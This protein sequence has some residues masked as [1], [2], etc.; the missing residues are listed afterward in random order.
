MRHIELEEPFSC[1]PEV[2][3]FG[4]EIRLLPFLRSEDLMGEWAVDGMRDVLAR[5]PDSQLPLFLGVCRDLQSEIA[6]SMD[7]HSEEHVDT[8]IIPRLERAEWVGEGLVRMP[9]A[10]RQSLDKFLSKDYVYDFLEEYCRANGLDDEAE[11][12]D[13]APDDMPEPLFDQEGNGEVET[14]PPPVSAPTEKIELLD[15]ASFYAIIGA[16]FWSEAGRSKY[17]D[18]F[19]TLPDI[20]KD[21]PEELLLP[22]FLRIE[23]DLQ[24]VLD[25]HDCYQLIVNETDGQGPYFAEKGT[26]WRT[27]SLE[28][29]RR[30]LG[31]YVEKQNWES[32][33]YG[34]VEQLFESYTEHLKFMLVAGDYSDES[35]DAASRAIDEL[36][37][38]VG[39]RQPSY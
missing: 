27:F 14:C 6:D 39:T 12:D 28:A 17:Q 35:L 7:L 31:D 8:I 15:Q 1:E 16:Y 34:R 9:V 23:E 32:A 25:D 4:Q 3:P 20:V 11:S 36:Y 21:A 38:E 30:A 2:S 26:I 13:E 5:I 29:I 37:N 10:D 19:D 22:L 24:I 18:L 33:G